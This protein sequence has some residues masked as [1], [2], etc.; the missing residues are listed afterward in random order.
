MSSLSQRALRTAH[1]VASLLA[2]S[3]NGF[4]PAQAQ[5]PARS[6]TFVV[7]VNAANPLEE[8]DREALSNLFLKRAIKWPSGNLAEP[9]DLGLRDPSREAFSRQVLHK[10]VPAVRSYWQQQ[11]FSGRDVPPP[12][13]GSD[14]DVLAVV[15]A[16]PHAVGYVSAS[17]S[18]PAGVKVLV[19]KGTP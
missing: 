2:A 15:K 5:A 17:A 1:L 11:I 7:V 4:R 13:K 9:F 12:E 3:L 14:D 10:S 6:A 18:L 8:I 19:I 16:A